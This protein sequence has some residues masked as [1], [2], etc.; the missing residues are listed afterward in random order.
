L[1]GL[2]SQGKESS[3]SAITLQRKTFVCFYD[4]LFVLPEYTKF[5][6]ACHI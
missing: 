6:A 4:N 2:T 1:G 5:F 3:K